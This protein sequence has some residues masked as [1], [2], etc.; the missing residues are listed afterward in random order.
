[1]KTLWLI[2]LMASCALSG[3]AG[4]K[5]K[6]TLALRWQPL[7]AEQNLDNYVVAESDVVQ[8]HKQLKSSLAKL[9]MDVQLGYINS[10]AKAPSKGERVGRLWIGKQTLEQCLADL[11]ETTVPGQAVSSDVIVKAGLGAA[12]KMMAAQ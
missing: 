2:A 9:G 11:Q 1:M 6:Q 10:D 8:A 5:Y 4:E 12:S 3:F 7:S